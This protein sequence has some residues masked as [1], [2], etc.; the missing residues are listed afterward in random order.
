MFKEDKVPVRAP[1]NFFENKG[2][3]AL[4]YKDIAAR[5]ND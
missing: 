2:I 3:E 4:S 1:L 5:V